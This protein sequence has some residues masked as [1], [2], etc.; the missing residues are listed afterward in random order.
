VRV[1]VRVQCRV[2][3]YV[4]VCVCVCVF[5]SVIAR[6]AVFDRTRTK[7]RGGEGGVLVVELELDA[8]S[9]RSVR[10]RLRTT[11]DERRTDPRWS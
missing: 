7:N 8:R 6:L 5:W 3:Q 10:S 4:C 2:F 1:R 9:V 11:N